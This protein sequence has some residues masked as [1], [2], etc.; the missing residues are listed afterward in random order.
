MSPADWFVIV[1]T[2]V[3]LEISPTPH[4]VVEQRGGNNIVDGATTGFGS[5]TIGTTANL[6][7][8]IRNTGTGDLS[9]LDCAIDG[10]DAN[11]FMVLNA[12]V[13]SVPPGGTT[14]FDL[15]F[16]PRGVGAKTAAL[17]IASN[18]SNRNPFDITLTGTGTSHGIVVE[19]PPGWGLPNSGVRDFG[20]IATGTN[21]YLTF[22]V[23]NFGDGNLTGLGIT[24][25]GTGAAD[26][27]VVESPVAPVPP[28]GGTTFKV[29]F[30]PT[31]AGLRSAVLHLA[32]N[33]SS[34]NP[35]DIVLTGNSLSPTSDTDHDGLNDWA[36]Y[37]LASLGF[38]WQVDNSAM[39]RDLFAGGNPAGLFTAPQVQALHADT[40]LLT[41]NPATGRFTLTIKLETSHDLLNYEPFPVSAPQVTVN[42]HGDLEI[43]FGPID[44]AAFFR[45]GVK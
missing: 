19:E 5:V 44:N 32:S 40:P 31:T 24:I 26:F 23:R 4:I 9:G 22:T 25:D 15:R 29:G 38:D 42:A 18:D 43:E 11:D 41:R 27:T 2:A 14:T 17:H 30:A 33:D 20:M 37:K 35:F 1:C 8:T 7:F 21:A 13:A 16:S 34:E 45:L 3:T 6:S 10:T 12:P 39:V 28:G 36:E